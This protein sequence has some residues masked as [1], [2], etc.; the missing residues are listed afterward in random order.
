[1]N[2]GKL[3]IITADF[4]NVGKISMNVSEANFQNVS[5]KEKKYFL[6]EW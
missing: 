5:G 1:M 3:D 6:L 4:I 2:T